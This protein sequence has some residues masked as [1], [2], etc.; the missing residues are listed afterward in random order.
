MLL[1]LSNPKALV[2]FVAL[3]P[4]FVVPEEPIAPQILILGVTSLAAE[5]PVLV[6]YSVLAGRA[7]HLAREPRFA[8]TIDVLAGALLIVAAMGIALG[9]SAAPGSTGAP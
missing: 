2:F 7:S 9:G 6:G 1:Q 8:R 4:Q 5:F 3:L